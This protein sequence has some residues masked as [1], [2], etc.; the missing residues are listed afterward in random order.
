[1]HTAHGFTEDFPGVKA[2]KKDTQ[3][4]M[5]AAPAFDKGCRPEPCPP[6]SQVL[7]L[8]W[9][10]MAQLGLN[11]SRLRDDILNLVKT[12]C[13]NHLN[14]FCCIILYPNTAIHGKGQLDSMRDETVREAKQKVK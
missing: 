2:S 11:H 4:G 7:R 1:M 3:S 12:G 13:E 9:I 5:K 10:H 6:P 8:M 14:I